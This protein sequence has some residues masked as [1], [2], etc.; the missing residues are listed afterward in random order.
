MM[1]IYLIT[2]LNIM[3]ASIR[4]FHTFPI[5]PKPRIVQT[6]ITEEPDRHG[7][8]GAGEGAGDGGAAELLAVATVGHLHVVVTRGH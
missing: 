2:T 7:V 6:A 8:V 3:N 1:M 5:S 4:T